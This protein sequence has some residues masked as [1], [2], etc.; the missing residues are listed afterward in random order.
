MAK[1]WLSLLKIDREY[2]YY[3]GKKEL[4]WYINGEAAEWLT[5]YQ[6]K[7]S[8]LKWPVFEYTLNKASSAI[9]PTV[10]VLTFNYFSYN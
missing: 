7:L 5:V 6:K 10:M 2:E 3:I 8:P 4:V 1:T 9:L